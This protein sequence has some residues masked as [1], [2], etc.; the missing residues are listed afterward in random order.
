MSLSHWGDSNQDRQEVPQH[1]DG[2]NH[3]MEEDKESPSRAN[4]HKEE[5]EVETVSLARYMPDTEKIPLTIVKEMEEM[6]LRLGFIQ[7]MAMK[8][9][10]DRRIDSL[11]TLTSLSDEEIAI[12]C[13][14]IRRP[15]D[16]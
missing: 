15:V 13:N 12:I 8:L 16:L 5:D 14:V 10:D 1:P 2:D 3:Y 9:V 4:N 6:F 7:I 11:W